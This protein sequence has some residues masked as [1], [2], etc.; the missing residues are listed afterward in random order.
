[1]RLFKIVALPTL[2]VL[3]CIDQNQLSFT[4]V[5]E[6]SRD[7]AGCYALLLDHRLL[8]SG[9]YNSSPFVQLDPGSRFP[10]RPDF[11][12]LRRLEEPGQYL[13]DDSV[14]RH[15]LFG[16]WVDSSQTLHVSFV[17]GFSGA[18]LALR[19]AG[20]D[21]LEGTISE[22]WD[23]GPPFETSRAAAQAIRV[24]C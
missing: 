3:A 5:H 12:P 22:H 19:S 6:A 20:A 2:A 7:P 24:R 10:R 11:H 1:M 8:D 23:V 16:W 18:V 15:T 13:D 21:T 4:P 9:Y 17:N 14:A